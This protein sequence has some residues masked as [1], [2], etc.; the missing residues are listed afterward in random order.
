MFFRLKNTIHY[1]EELSDKDNS[2]LFN[3]HIHKLKYRY[4]PIQLLFLLSI[5]PLFY[6]TYSITLLLLYLLFIIIQVYFFYYSISYFEQSYSNF[7]QLCKSILQFESITKQMLLLFKHND[8][9]KSK[10]NTIISNLIIKISS[11]INN[12]DK[13][14]Q[15]INN[16][17]NEYLQLK[18]KIFNRIYTIYRNEYCLNQTHF[19]ITLYNITNITIQSVITAIDLSCNDMLR[20]TFDWNSY[21]NENTIKHDNNGNISSREKDIILNLFEIMKQNMNCNNYCMNIIKKMYLDKDNS[22]LENDIDEVIA[23]KHMC[24]ANLQ[25]IKKEITLLKSNENDINK[26]G[27]NNEINKE[28]TN[29]NEQ[30]KENKL[31]DTSVS[32]FELQLNSVESDL[33]NSSNNNKQIPITMTNPLDII[34]GEQEVRELKFSLVEELE[35][36]YQKNNLNS[37]TNNFNAVEHNE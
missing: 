27:N 34:R 21:P 4:L 15:N 32:L 11:I 31:K 10:V 28:C 29:N 2:Q 23:N 13:V 36:Y 5:V 19:S 8:Q 6:F 18:E 1:L 20:V 24:M 22:N 26:E 37:I 3:S 30:N 35:Q 16:I 33:S 7:I 12:K 9:S 14:N 17:Y 25:K